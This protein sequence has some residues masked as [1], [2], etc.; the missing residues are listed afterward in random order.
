MP[1]QRIESSRLA[2]PRVMLFDW[3]G[4]LVDTL[5]AMYRTMEEMLPQLEELDLIRHLVPEDQCRSADDI[6]L[7]RYIRIFRKLHPKILAE[8]RVS[9]TEIFNA[10]F[11]SNTEA[12]RIAHQAYN[13]CYR[14][15]YGEV[16]PFQGGLYEYLGT[17]RRLGIKLAIATNR[18]R[19][20]LDHELDLVEQGRWKALFDTTVCADDV[21]E[22]KPAPD[23]I[24]QTLLNLNEPCSASVWYVGDS[25]TD[26]LTAYNAGITPVFYNGAH[27]E[28]RWIDRIIANKEQNPEAPALVVDSFEQLLNALQEMQESGQAT[29]LIRLKD[30][31]P[32]A[33]PPR[34]PP[35]PRIEPNWHPN[36]FR[37]TPPTLVLFDWHAT[38]VDTLDAMYHAVDDML[39]E[40]EP[41]GLIDRLIQPEQSKSPEDARLVEH[42][43]HYQQLHPKVKA[44]RKISR[45]DIFEVLFGDDQLAKKIAHK[46]FNRHY[47]SHYGTVLPFEPQVRQ[48]LEG[49]RKLNLQVGVITNRDREFF[50]HELAAVE[51]S[52]WSH[53]FD[54]DIC[55]D[56]TPQRKPHPDQIYL[57]CQRLEHAVNSAVWYVGD[58]TTDTIASKMAGVT[59]VFFNGAQWDLTWLEKIFPGNTRYPHKPDVVVNDFSEFWALVLACYQS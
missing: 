25:H 41:L 34:E 35:P 13:R 38:L 29:F 8:R 40:L 48:M 44:D 53:L 30:H 33:W 16:K 31:R 52:G 32:P 14:K 42:V 19:E 39:P 15:H 49:L 24:H 6:K 47:R 11:A 22:Y 56:D 2:P 55:G 20:F 43:R 1:Q 28:E 51:G 59:S 45:T 26:M 58:S 4:T 17:L 36:A 27:W 46:A 18:S 50:V 12:K 10:I 57:A 5:D 54:T 7:V 23:V 3:H 21:T 37:L 9:R